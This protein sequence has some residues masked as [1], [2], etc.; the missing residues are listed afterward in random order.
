L[1]SERETPVL[2]VVIPVWDEYVALLPRCLDA[3][4]QQ[5]TPAQ[6]VIV[7]NASRTPVHAPDGAVL[8]KLAT[9][10][11]VGAARNA[12]LQHV[13]TPYVVFAD[14]DDEVA[15]GSLARGIALL[16]KHPNA[17][18]VFG[19]S[20]VDEQGAHRRGITPSTRYQLASRYAPP[21][22]PLLWLAKFQGSITSTVLRTETVRAAGGFADSN[23]NEDWQLAARLARHGQLVC[24]DRPVR[25]Y[26]RHPDAL[27]TRDR[28]PTTSSGRS[29]IC[30]DC[31]ADPS[32]TPAQKLAAAIL[33]RS[34][35][36]TATRS[37]FTSH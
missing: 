3:I 34:H 31:R 23:I 16:D 21:V 33:A 14:A 4:Q 13:T 37:L 28:H 29:L 20:L 30:S 22:V 35:A 27:R 8:V 2:T 36:P 6:L 7:D 17:P 26:H 10:Q 19:R 18:G 24:I 25:I 15:P 9:R 12:G 32:A 11:S 5:D 1:K